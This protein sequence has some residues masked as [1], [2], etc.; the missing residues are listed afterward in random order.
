[1]STREQLSTQLANGRTTPQKVQ[2]AHPRGSRGRT[3]GPVDLP[4]VLCQQPKHT[5]GSSCK[6]QLALRGTNFWPNVSTTTAASTPGSSFSG[7]HRHPLATAQNVGCYDNPSPC[8]SPK[9]QT[10]A[11][12]RASKR[13]EKNTSCFRCWPVLASIP[14]F[15]GGQITQFTTY[16]LRYGRR[17]WSLCKTRGKSV[18]L[19]ELP[20]FFLS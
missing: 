13:T 2:I 20:L 15:R 19:C 4:Q 9:K 16:N 17:W 14:R 12:G 5:Y 3:F 1:M 10:E 7:I 6:S 11:Q 18:V 8:E